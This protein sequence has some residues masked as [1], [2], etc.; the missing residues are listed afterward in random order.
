MTASPSPLSRLIP[1]LLRLYPPDWRA[2]YEEELASLLAETVLTPSAV[3]DI[4]LAALDARLSRDYPSEAG[5][6]RKVRRPMLDRLAPLAIVLGGMFLSIFVVVFLAVGSPEGPDSSGLMLLAFYVVPL[7]VGL[8]AIG[9]GGIA[10]RRPGRDPVA[11]GLGLLA[12][13]SGLALA[14]AILLL[15]FVGDVAWT[16]LSLMMPAFALASG[17]LGLRM[18]TASTGARLQ[19]V[20][21]TAGLIAAFAWTVGWYLGESS[22]SVSAQQIASVIQTLGF[23]VV[24]VGWLAVGLLDLRDDTRSDGQ[25]VAAA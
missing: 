7:A 4:A 25:R 14:V 18:L 11:R 20:L 21:L 5:A 10:L 23:G 17:L 15:F 8:L 24:F 12:S 13:A 6:G 3:L 2:R 22:A 16:S 9:I 19:S 1:M